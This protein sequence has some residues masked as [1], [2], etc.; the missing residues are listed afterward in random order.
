MSAKETPEKK[1][2][3]FRQAMDR[4][5]PQLSGQEEE[6][7]IT[8]IILALRLE[9][10]I[11]KDMSEREVGL[12]NMLTDAVLKNKTIKDEALKV[13]LKLVDTK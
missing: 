10:L 1:L 9:G 12:V 3:K 5:R 13:A 11:G 8:E 7:V 2:Y 4:I 6:T